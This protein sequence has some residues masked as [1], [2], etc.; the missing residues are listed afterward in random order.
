MSVFRIE[1]LRPKPTRTAAKNNLS[2]PRRVEPAGT[3]TEDH[4]ESVSGV[5]LEQRIDICD[6]LR[7]VIDR[8][9]RI[10]LSV[11]RVFETEAG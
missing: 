3:L 6:P 2:Y 4:L 8:H 7:D 10:C 1:Q 11:V 9:S 5:F